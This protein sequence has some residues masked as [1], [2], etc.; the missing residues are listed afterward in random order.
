[1]SPELVMP[2]N[3]FILFTPISSCPQFFPASGSFPVGQLFTS[4]GQN[5]G[6]SVSASVL[7]FNI[8]ILFPLGLTGL[9]SLFSKGLPRV[10]SST[11]VQ[12][13]QFFSAHP[14][15]WCNSHIHTWLLEKQYLWLDEPLS[16]KWCLCFLICC[17]GWSYLFF[18]GASIFNFMAAV[19]VRSDFGAQEN[20]IKGA[21]IW[22]VP[23]YHCILNI[24]FSIL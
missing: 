4:G 1:M 17:L 23:I 8:Q 12:K 6:A 21:L 14:S 16:A 3:Y 18:Q 20:K 7:P 2:S 10:F 22:I 24:A 9:I 19:T 5:I 15:L 13:H 11:R